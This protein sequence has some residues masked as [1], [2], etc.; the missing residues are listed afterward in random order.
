MANFVIVEGEKGPSTIDNSS[1]NLE[2][3][4]GGIVEY[5]DVAVR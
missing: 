4:G 2:G 5:W 3:M 1:H